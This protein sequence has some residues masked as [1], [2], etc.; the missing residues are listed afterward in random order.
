MCWETIENVMATAGQATGR[1]QQATSTRPAQTK[2]NKIK[3][4]VRSRDS[5]PD[6]RGNDG[7]KSLLTCAEPPMALIREASWFRP[8]FSSKKSMIGIAKKNGVKQKFKKEMDEWE[9]SE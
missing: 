7:S 2:G 5:A 8:T 3:R 4:K 1:Q 6:R 9:E